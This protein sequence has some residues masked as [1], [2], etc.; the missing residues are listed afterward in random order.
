LLAFIAFIKKSLQQ[1]ISG[2]EQKLLAVA[3]DNL[4]SL[5]LAVYGIPHLFT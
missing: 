2:M 3:T 5:T 1:V 4:S